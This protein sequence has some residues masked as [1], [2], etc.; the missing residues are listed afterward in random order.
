MSLKI[1]PPQQIYYD[2]DGTPLDAGFIYIGQVSQNPETNQVAVY[3]DSALTLPAPQPIRTLN[4]YPSRQGVIANIYT[5]SSFSITVKSKRKELVFTSSFGNSSGSNYALL[6]FPDYA[7]ASAA[8]ATLPNGQPIEI[9]M[10]ETHGG[11]STKN[12][13]Q[14]G[15]LV[16][17]G[18]SKDSVWSGDFP[19]AAN[20]NSRLSL[21]MAS[22]PSRKIIEDGSYSLQS[23]WQPDRADVDISSGADVSFTGA[24]PDFRNLI[25]FQAGPIWSQNLISKTYSADWKGGGNIFQLA[26]YVTSET[27]D[28]YTNGKNAVAVY[29]GADSRGAGSS[30]WGGNFVAYANSPTATSI[31]IELNCGTLVNGG[32]S[33]GLVIASAGNFQPQN[34]IQ[35]Q[36]N[37]IAS[38]FLDGIVFRY[39]ELVGGITGSVFRIVGQ[40]DALSTCENFLKVTSVVATQSEI[41]TPSF[42][43]NATQPNTVNRLAVRGAST[44]SPP[45]LRATGVDTDVSLNYVSKGAGQH[46]FTANGIEVLRATATVGTDSLQVAA[47]TG[48]AVLSVRGGTADADVVVQGKG[49]AGVRL[50]GGDSSVKFRVNTV[51]IGFYNTNPVAK[52]TVSGS[53]NGNAALASLIQALA[54]LG[55]ITDAS[56]S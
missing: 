9:N 54:D 48:A 40:G 39:R 7:S 32:L 14:S 24:Y 22:P 45:S 12:V 37:N 56:T 55:L 35:V 13:V 44:G 36:N 46:I 42:L 28:L 6:V 26:S 53:R 27:T 52:P 4:G 51:G 43:V 18:F 19:S 33:Y 10:D 38:R 23:N 41:E 2:K 49:T 15:S 1:T 34:A 47:G 21:M 17:T 3:W 8:A 5:A 25:P 11:R 31:G 20:D 16:F 50:R 30:V 29:G